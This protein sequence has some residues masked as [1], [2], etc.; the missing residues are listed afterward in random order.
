M[1]LLPTSADLEVELLEVFV[2]GLVAEASAVL[3]VQRFENLR[4]EYRVRS[5]QGL[6]D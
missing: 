4:R 3:R 5:N 6:V 1:R 2:D